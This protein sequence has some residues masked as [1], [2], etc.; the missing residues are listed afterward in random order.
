MNV[1]AVVTNVEAFVMNAIL[2]YKVQIPD[3][4]DKSS[5]SG[6]SLRDITRFLSYI[7]LKKHNI[8]LIMLISIAGFVGQASCIIF[9]S[10][11]LYV[12]EKTYIALFGES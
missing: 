2:F 12:S 5:I 1:E 7:I 6:R 9:L 10:E 11:Y 3:F 8:S 4:L